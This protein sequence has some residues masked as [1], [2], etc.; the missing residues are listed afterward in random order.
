MPMWFLGSAPCVY[1][2]CFE[3]KFS[4]AGT[5]FCWWTVP[6]TDRTDPSL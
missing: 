6:N 3:C 1:T 5:V 4:L 2:I